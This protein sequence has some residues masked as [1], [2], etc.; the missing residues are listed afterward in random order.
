[1]HVT[2]LS[3]FRYTFG[4]TFVRQKKVLH[5][6]PD[7]PVMKQFIIFSLISAFCLIFNSLDARI[8]TANPDKLP[9]PVQN[10]IATH[11]PSLRITIIKIDS[12]P[13]QHYEV[14]LSNGYSIIFPKRGN[15]TS[16]DGGT[17]NIPASFLPD[18]IGKYLDSIHA[19]DKIC[20][21]KRDKSSYEISLDNG[22]KLYF[23]KKGVLDESE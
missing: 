6:F 7:I 11:F 20:A 22:S 14:L 3:F 12:D 16:I 10:F 1:M 2:S 15:W 18:N 19:S 21:I 9:L 4:I 13:K 23:N 5:P 17:E 8:I